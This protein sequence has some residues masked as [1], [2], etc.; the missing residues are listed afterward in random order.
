MEERIEPINTVQTEF[1]EWVQNGLDKAEEIIHK[2]DTDNI[3]KLAV[4]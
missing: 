3:K 2:S 4:F 1:D